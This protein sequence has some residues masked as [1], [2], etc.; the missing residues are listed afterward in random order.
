[1]KSKDFLHYIKKVGVDKGGA[2][3]SE[4]GR[5]VR[6]MG[7]NGKRVRM[8]LPLATQLSKYLRQYLSNT[9]ENIKKYPVGIC[10]ITLSDKKPVSLLLLLLY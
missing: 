4:L 8:S 5:S 3:L 6:L 7:G 2:L 9:V 10:F 1:M